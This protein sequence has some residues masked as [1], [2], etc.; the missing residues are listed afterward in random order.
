MDKDNLVK[1]ARESLDDA[2]EMIDNFSDQTSCWIPF[3]IGKAWAYLDAAYEAK[4][5]TT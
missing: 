4:G 1:M 5:E 2:M 3:Y